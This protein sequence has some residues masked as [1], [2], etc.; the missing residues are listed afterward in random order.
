MPDFPLLHLDM[1]GLGQGSG[2]G[3]ASHWFA[4]TFIN[5]SPLNATWYKSGKPRGR[6]I[7]GR[8]LV[9]APF[10]K[11]VSVDLVERPGN[12]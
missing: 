10:L 12:R 8:A 2:P 7:F 3:I 9:G 11:R 1:P 5:S 6:M 4:M